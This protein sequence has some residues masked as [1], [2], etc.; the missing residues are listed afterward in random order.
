MAG[1]LPRS[2][3]NSTKPLLSD[4]AMKSPC[5]SEPEYNIRPSACSAFNIT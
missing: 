4:K 2:K 5:F 3:T 1:P